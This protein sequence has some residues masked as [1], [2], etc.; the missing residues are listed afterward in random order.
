MLKR[1]QSTLTNI[2]RLSNKEVSELLKNTP[3]P[4]ANREDRADAAFSNLMSLYNSKKV[5]NKKSSTFSSEFLFSHP[6]LVPSHPNEPYTASELALRMKHYNGITAT[7]S[8]LVGVHR[9]HKDVVNPPRAKDVTVKK[10]LA[11]GV[12]LGRSTKLYCPESQGSIYGEYKGIHIVDLEKTLSALRSAARVVEKVVENGGIVLFVGLQSGQLRAVR[13]AA[14]KC[15]G[16]YVV[17]K[18]HAGAITNA[19][20]LPKKRFEIDMGDLPTGRE[21]T[22]DEEKAVIKPDLMVVLNPESCAPALKE[23]RQMRI[24]TVGICDTNCDPSLVNYAIPGNN[25]STRSVNLLVGVLGKAGEMG[26]KRRLDA[27]AQYKE[28]LGMDKNDVFN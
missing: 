4:S 21:L 27:V 19:L 16:S 6:H 10:L 13:N 28:N 12:H 18:W 25:A 11:S 2:A 24:P 15:N 14:E 1:S 17:K 7:G 8:N 9:P 26:L 20:E 23:A 3:K 22:Q 5:H